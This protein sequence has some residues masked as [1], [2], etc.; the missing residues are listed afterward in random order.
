MLPLLYLSLTTGQV[1]SKIGPEGGKLRLG[2]AMPRG[3]RVVEEVEEGAGGELRYQ[4]FLE[5]AGDEG[6]GGLPS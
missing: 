6:G 2:N 4:A 1:G 3:L 5:G